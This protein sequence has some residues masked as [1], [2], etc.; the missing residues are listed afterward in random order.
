[1]EFDSAVQV[2]RIPWMQVG[3]TSARDLN[4]GWVIPKSRS[5]KKAG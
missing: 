3:R 4:G 1:M 5:A 2:N